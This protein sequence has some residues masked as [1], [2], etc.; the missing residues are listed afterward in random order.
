MILTSLSLKNFRSYIK[1]NI[2]FSPTTTI[3]VGPNTAGKTNIVEAIYAG[4]TGKSFRADKD[5][6]MIRW[7]A[8]VSSITC[9]VSHAGD[10]TK[11]E[12]FLTQGE[13]LGQKAPMKK[14]LVNGIPRRQIDFI[15]NLRVVLFWPQ[16]LELVTG[17]PGMRRRYLD[18]VLIQ[19][20]REYRRNLFSYERGVRQR[21]KLLGFI[22]EGKAQ[23]NQLFFWD[24]LIIKVGEYLTQ[25]RA[26]FIDFVNQCPMTSVHYQ[27]AYDKSVISEARL[28]QYK[29]EE[30]S[31]KAT[32]VG[33]HRDD[34]IISIKRQASGIKGVK[35]LMDLSKFGSRGEQRLAILWIKLA[36]LRFIEETVGDR[37]VLILDDIFSELDESHR[38]IV[39]ELMGKQQNILTSCDAAVL[40]RL[41]IDR[42]DMIKLM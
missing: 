32:L 13:V 36:E 31:A 23:R 39:F 19:V 27:I 15:G 35:D 30:V 37:P 38:A 34:F 17:S 42:A 14:H 18:S 10:E 12:L 25:K 22:C 1:K 41:V 16:D 11:L 8:E 3:I 40:P 21:N 26:E 33:P 4:A 2:E 24:Q 5:Q 9:Q 7:N 6:E 29:D 20:D 28:E